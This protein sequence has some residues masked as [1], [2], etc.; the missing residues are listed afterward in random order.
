[1]VYFISSLFAMATNTVNFIVSIS[2]DNVCGILHFIKIANCV[3]FSVMVHISQSFYMYLS[4]ND[5][6]V[7]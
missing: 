5:I 2:F 1:M 7:V 4:R 6:V 3:L